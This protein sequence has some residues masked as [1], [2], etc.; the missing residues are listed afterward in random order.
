MGTFARTAQPVRSPWG[1][2]QVATETAP[3]IWFVS[4]AS[5]GGFI[6]SSQRRAAMP[7]R[8]RRFPTFCGD[9]LAFEED[10]DCLA[11]VA[12]WPEHFTAEQV[13]TARHVIAADPYFAD[14][15]EG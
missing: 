12:A 4:T 8:L 1:L 6:I 11:V 5:H 3:G 7:E 10:M 14:A 15:R 2:V 13:E 9:P